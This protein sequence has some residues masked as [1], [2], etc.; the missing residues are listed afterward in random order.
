MNTGCPCMDALINWDP[1]TSIIDLMVELQIMLSEPVIEGCVNGP[2]GE[3]Y[4]KS[5]KNYKQMVQDSIVASRRVEGMYY[6]VVIIIAGL[7]PFERFGEE[8]PLTVEEPAIQSSLS[9]K[10]SITH[11]SFDNYHK[12]WLDLATSAKPSEKEYFSSFRKEQKE[13]LQNH[14]YLIYGKF[15]KSDRKASD[16]EQKKKNRLQYLKAL[17]Q[18]PEPAPVEAT[19]WEIEA[20]ELL[21][22]TKSLI[23]D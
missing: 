11:L 10:K 20:Q 15:G 5:P 7:D 19:A 22:W 1:K 3:I 6:V 12:Q 9:E 16:L 4:L 8:E 23:T 17:Y 13:L 14:K 2:A 21:E 18:K